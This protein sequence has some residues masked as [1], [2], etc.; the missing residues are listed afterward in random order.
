MLGRCTLNSTGNLIAADGTLYTITG[1]YLY[2][3]KNN[4]E[5]EFNISPK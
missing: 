3:H 2:A 4:N 5:D 1:I